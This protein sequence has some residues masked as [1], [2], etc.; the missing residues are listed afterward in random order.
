MPLLQDKK[1]RW[2]VNVSYQPTTLK[3][4]KAAINFL[5]DNVP[6]LEVA[7]SVT[8]F[9]KADANGGNGKPGQASEKQMG[10]LFAMARDNGFGHPVAVW[11][12][13]YPESPVK[14]QGFSSVEASKMITHLESLN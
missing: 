2:L 13:V 6:P 1:S 10:K 11:K 5:D 9:P 4:F 14:R 7:V 3:E 12:E 8:P